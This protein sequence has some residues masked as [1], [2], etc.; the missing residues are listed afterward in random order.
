MRDPWKE[1]VIDQAV[2]CHILKPEH[3]T[4]PRQ[5]LADVI[6]YNAKLA[7]DPLVSDEARELIAKAREDEKNA[8]YLITKHGLCLSPYHPENEYNG[9]PIESVTLWNVNTPERE[10]QCLESL[11]C[12][13]EHLGD[14]VF[15]AVERLKEEGL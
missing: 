3:D 15:E 6:D 5:C 11:S 8:L 2:V 12:T 14:A 1:A 10:E 4:D 7:L 13:K 9:E